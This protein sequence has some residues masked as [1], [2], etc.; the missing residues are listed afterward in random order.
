[1]RSWY[2]FG[3][4]EIGY[5]G[6]NGSV[7]GVSYGQSIEERTAEQGNGG[8]FANNSSDGS[9]YAK[10]AP[11][12]AA[13][14]SF[15]QGA[16]SGSYTVRAGDTLSSIASNIYGDSSL[17][18]KIAQ[19]NGLSGETTLVAGQ[20]LSL[21]SG[22][23]VNT[24]NDSTFKPYNPAE[25]IGDVA[26]PK[27]PSDNNCGALGTVLIIIVAVVVTYYTGGW[28]SSALGNMGWGTAAA[29][30]GGAVIGGAA[31][32]IASQQTAVSLGMRDEI[33]WN[34]VATTA[35]GAGIGAGISSFSGGAAS[36]A[37][38]GV[39]AGN[40]GAKAA[41]ATRA[42]SAPT[43]KSI[44]SAFIR[45]AVGNALTNSIADGLGWGDFSWT[46]VAAAGVGAAAAESVFLRRCN[47]KIGEYKGR[48]IQCISRP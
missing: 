26:S 1:M 39:G 9:V 6:N 17:W 38:T 28:A 13:L 15:S 41:A 8:A 19:A 45:G 40:E 16:A 14:S 12:I 37:T 21:P 7:N 24:Y 43:L 47:G 4:A 22:V 11:G 48:Q 44:G 3:G 20:I 46:G 27:P 31:G 32:S 34:E 10:F 35:L 2:R 30:I 42:A 5:I 29:N 18:Y 23:Q 25:V 33:S 36:G